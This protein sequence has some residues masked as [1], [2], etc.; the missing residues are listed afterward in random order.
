LVTYKYSVSTFF[1]L[2]KAV[3]ILFEYFVRFFLGKRLK[4]KA[5]LPKYMDTTA[6][7]IYNLFYLETCLAF[8]IVFNKNPDP[9]CSGSGLFSFYTIFISS[10]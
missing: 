10:E 4:E 2:P 3:E 1:G 7:S 8:V 9:D 5:L 6:L